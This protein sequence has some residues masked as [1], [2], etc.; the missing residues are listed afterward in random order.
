MC[1]PAL[2]RAHNCGLLRSFVGG[3]QPA[4]ELAST[5]GS[6]C[7]QSQGSKLWRCYPQSLHPMP[8]PVLSPSPIR[9]GRRY[10]VLSDPGLSGS[11]SFS[12]TGGKINIQSEREVRGRGWEGGEVGEGRERS[13]EWCEPHPSD[14]GPCVNKGSSRGSLQ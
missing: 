2:E 10:V 7:R 14:L 1:A 3:F 9:V 6:F 13:S 12:V 8:Q 4:L 5:S 11:L